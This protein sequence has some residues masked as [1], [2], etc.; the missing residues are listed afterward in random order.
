MS[1]RD[2]SQQYITGVSIDIGN[3]FVSVKLFNFEFFI[4]SF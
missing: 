4:T 3:T 2:Y 1:E